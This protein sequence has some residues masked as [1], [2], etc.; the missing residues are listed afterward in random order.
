MDELLN[1][2]CRNPLHFPQQFNRNVSKASQHQ[3]SGSP[4]AAVFPQDLLAFVEG[5]ASNE[6]CV[7][8]R[9]SAVWL[10]LMSGCLADAE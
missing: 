5:K 7:A 9:D 6:T 1:L 8:T 3:V 4:E 10:L 2:P